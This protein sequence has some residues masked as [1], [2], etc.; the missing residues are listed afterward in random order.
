MTDDQIN[1]LNMAESTSTV[2]GQNEVIWADSPV[3]V[4]AKTALGS[5]ISAIHLQSQKQ[6]SDPKGYTVSKK[7][8]KLQLIDAALHAIGALATHAVDIDDQV[9]LKKIAFTEYNLTHCREQELV[10]KSGIIA[11]AAQPLLQTLAGHKYKESDYTAFTTLINS[12]E[13]SIPLRRAAITGIST[14]TDNLEIL[15]RDLNAVLRNKLDFLILN[16]RKSHPDFF[17]AYTSARIIVDLGKRTGNKQTI[18]SG[19]ITN[20]ETEN[21]IIGVSVLCNETG[22]I[23]FTDVNGKYSHTLPDG[24][25]YTFRAMLENFTSYDTDPVTLL[26]GAHV[27]LD[28]ELEPVE[29]PA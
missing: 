4:R 23:V 7:S 17:K 28:I 20:F 18:I 24:G 10:D 15:F 25:T 21:P 11:D 26:K 14:A 1:K 19:V 27:T 12:F 2:I 9:L 16:Y 5:T 3:F 29:Q 22:K 8:I 13:S 6:G